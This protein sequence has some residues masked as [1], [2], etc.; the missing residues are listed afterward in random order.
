MV[1]V[2]SVAGAPAGLKACQLAKRAD[3]AMAVSFIV[4]LQLV[5]IVAAPLWACA[6]VTGATVQA[7][8]II[9]DL[10]ILV[11]IPLVAGLVVKAR[12]GED[13]ASWKAGLEKT[14]NIA[15]YIAIAGGVPET[16]RR[17]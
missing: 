10:L 13:S 11:L 7:W 9:K 6:V 2:I 12:Y 15:L 5:N 4:G 17:S 3:M 14:S 8:T 1:R 16:G